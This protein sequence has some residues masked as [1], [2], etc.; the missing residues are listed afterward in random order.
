M[1]NKKTLVIVLAVAAA[2]TMALVI[3][4]LAM[5]QGTSPEV[6][7]RLT[8]LTRIRASTS[9]SSILDHGW[10]N[11]GTDAARIPRVHAV[12]L[13]S[14]FLD[15][16]AP[17]AYFNAVSSMT[18]YGINVPVMIGRDFG[19]AH[20]NFTFRFSMQD[21]STSRSISSQSFFGF[22]FKDALGF[23]LFKVGVESV[24]LD[25]GLIYVMRFTDA[26]G[27][28]TTL[29]A[30]SYT[31]QHAV[32]IAYDRGAV[33]IHDGLAHA[34]SVPATG[35]Q[36]VHYVMEFATFGMAVTFPDIELATS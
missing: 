16:P 4:P 20:V 9:G 15:A 23:V 11:E 33:L 21:T 34:F 22:V 31:S 25:G 35:V 26:I 10:M 8:G 7:T 32:I 27:I 12:L 1:I 19:Q 18:D 14:A 28:K 36:S 17:H 6:A 2:S 13:P 24:S 30:F 3:V 29:K 5:Q